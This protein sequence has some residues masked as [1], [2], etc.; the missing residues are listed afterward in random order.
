MEELNLQI[1]ELKKELENVKGTECEI[2]SRICGY[3]RN[4]KNWNAGKRAEKNK[5]LV[6]KV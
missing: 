5:R 4:V 1:E 6:Y 3:H 2:F